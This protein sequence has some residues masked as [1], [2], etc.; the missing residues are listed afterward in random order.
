MIFRY[1]AALKQSVRSEEVSGPDA[2][3]A[4]TH[5][6]ILRIIRRQACQHFTLCTTNRIFGVRNRAWV[7][8]RDAHECERQSSFPPIERHKGTWGELA[9][10]LH[11]ILLTYLL[12]GAESFLR[13]QLVCSWNPKVHYRTHKRPPPVPILGGGLY[14][15][16][17]Y[18]K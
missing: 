1:S 13:S 8:L 9:V 3:P 7:W 5:Y 11:V 18:V 16:T 2:P 14:L 17:K 10:W 12:H 4:V 15:W 6:H